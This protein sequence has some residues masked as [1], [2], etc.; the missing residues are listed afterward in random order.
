MQTWKSACILLWCGLLYVGD[1]QAVGAQTPETK[2]PSDQGEALRVAPNAPSPTPEAKPSPDEVG[3]QANICEEL[4][5]FVQKPP[6]DLQTS[7]AAGGQ[8]AKPNGVKTSEDTAQQRSG[9]SKSIPGDD[10][11]STAAQLS[12]ERAQALVAT[13][14]LRACQRTAQEMRRAG[15]ALP[16]GLLALAALREDLLL[17][18]TP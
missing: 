18:K 8:P 1:M 13:N 16:P 7:A 2:A 10:T 11:T 4:L 15:V 5:A 17:G 12:L 14:D 9:I 6:A 3:K